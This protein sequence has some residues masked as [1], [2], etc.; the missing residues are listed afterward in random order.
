MVATKR[1]AFWQDIMT[2]G[3][4]IRLAVSPP[5]SRARRLYELFPASNMMAERSSYIN[6]GYWQ[7]PGDTLDDA[8]QALAEQLADHA[9]FREGDRVL[10]AGF[11]HGDEDFLWLQRHNLAKIVGLNVTP[12]HVRAAQ[13]KALERGLSDRLDFQEGSATAMNLA[14]G[15]FDRVVALESAFHFVPREEFFRQAYD[16]LRPGGVLAVADIVPINV[17]DAKGK[18]PFA[19]AYPDENWYEGGEYLARLRAAGFTNVRLTSIR[20]K[21]YEPWFGFMSRQ[22]GDPAFRQRT[23][24]LY[25][26]WLRRELNDEARMRRSLAGLDYVIVVAEKPE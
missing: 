12:T 17:S 5:A 24:K 1:S 4:M 6:M 15:S 26:S 22:V 10:D 20:E 25:Y 23:S 19:S 2:V 13:D 18:G 7:N 21:V 11:G 9:G 14:P 16:V 3:R 8:S